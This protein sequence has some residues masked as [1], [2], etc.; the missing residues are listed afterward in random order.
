MVSKKARQVISVIVAWVYMITSYGVGFIATT[1]TTGCSNKKDDPVNVVVK[2]TAPDITQDGLPTQIPT[3]QDVNFKVIATPT[4]NAKPYTVSMSVSYASS[5]NNAN[6]GGRSINNGY[7]KIND[8]RKDLMDSTPVTYNYPEMTAKKDFDITL[9]A[10]RNGRLQFKID[11]ACGNEIV[12]IEKLIEIKSTTINVVIT[13]PV[14]NTLAHPFTASLS[15]AQTPLQADIKSLR[16][17]VTYPNLFPSDDANDPPQITETFNFDP[18]KKITDISTYY[19]SIPRA[20]DIS[21]FVELIDDQDNKHS[22]TRVFSIPNT[23]SPNFGYTAVIH[24]TATPY[25]EGT[26]YFTGTQFNFTITNPIDLDGYITELRYRIMKS[27]VVNPIVDWTPIE[28]SGFNVAFPDAGNYSILLRAIDNGGREKT[29]TVPFIIKSAVG[30]IATINIENENASYVAGNTI[31]INASGS[32]AQSGSSISQYEWFLV[33]PDNTE[34]LLGTG[35]RLTANQLNYV[36]VGKVKLIVTDTANR[37]TIAYKNVTVINRE[38]SLVMKKG[39]VNGSV[40]NT[41]AVVNT[42]VREK[43][44]LTAVASD[45]DVAIFK[46]DTPIDTLAYFWDIGLGNGYQSS[47]NDYLEFTPM[48]PNTTRTIKCKVVDL[49]GGIKEQTITVTVLDKPVINADFEIQTLSGNGPTNYRADD[50]FTFR[51]VSSPTDGATLTTQDWTIRFYDANDNEITEYM[52]D[53]ISGGILS[54]Y[55]LPHIGKVKVELYVKDSLMNESRKEQFIEIGSYTPSIEEGS[56]SISPESGSTPLTLTID[57][58]VIDQDL[59]L[60]DMG[61]NN[62]DALKID[63]YDGATK[64]NSTSFTSFPIQQ[65]VSGIGKKNIKIRITDNY[66]KYVESQSYEITVLAEKPASAVI[67]TKLYDNLT[68]TIITQ[69]NGILLRGTESNGRNDAPIINYKWTLTRVVNSA[70]TTTV[71]KEGDRASAGEF[72]YVPTF[73]GEGII[74]LEITDSNDAIASTSGAGNAVV[75]VINT[76]PAATGTTVSATQVSDNSAVTLTVN[77]AIDPDI[78]NFGDSLT[79]EFRTHESEQWITSANNNYTFTLTNTSYDH[80]NVYSL[81]ARVKDKYNGTWVSSPVEVRVLKRGSMAASLVV[82]NQP[83][84]IYR[85]DMLQIKSNVTLSTGATFISEYKISVKGPN[86]SFTTLIENNNYNQ[87]TIPNYAYTCDKIGQMTFQ[88]Y[89]KDSMGQTKT[90]EGDLFAVQN[91]RPVAAFTINGANTS[92]DT[93]QIPLPRNGYMPHLVQLDASNS[94]DPDG[95]SDTITYYWYVY[96]YGAQSSSVVPVTGKTYSLN[97]TLAML[98]TPYVIELRVVDAYTTLENADKIQQT[99]QATNTNPTIAKLTMTPEGSASINITTTSQGP[100]FIV[101]KKYTFKAEEIADAEITAGYQN[102]VY[103]W[104]INNVVNSEYTGNNFEFIPT[105][106]NTT[107]S[108]KVVVNDGF[109]STEKTY[110]RTTTN[111]V[112]EITI[113]KYDYNYGTSTYSNT[114][115]ALPSSGYELTAY[116]PI[117]LHIG[118]NDPDGHT[119]KGTGTALSIK[120]DGI[121]VSVL[122]LFETTTATSPISKVFT[123]DPLSPDYPFKHAKNG[124]A[125]CVYTIEVIATDNYGLQ[126]TVNIPITIKSALPEYEFFYIQDGNNY[127]TNNDGYVDAGINITTFENKLQPLTD[128]KELPIK[129]NTLF[130][131]KVKDTDNYINSTKITRQT[132]ETTLKLSGRDPVINRIS[133]SSRPLYYEDYL[134]MNIGTILVSDNNKQL[135]LTTTMNDKTNL[136]TDTM[137]YQTGSVNVKFK[138]TPPVLKK[139]TISGQKMKID[140]VEYDVGD[141]NSNI[142]VTLFEQ[143]D[144]GVIITNISTVLNKIELTLGYNYTMN[145]EAI[146]ADG[147]IISYKG[148]VVEPNNTSTTLLTWNTSNKSFVIPVATKHTHFA[149][150]YSKIEL[151]Y[152]DEYMGESG[153]AVKSYEFTTRNAAPI[154]SRIEYA[155][156]KINNNGST[157]V[158]GF[159]YDKDQTPQYPVPEIPRDVPLNLTFHAY[160][161]DGFIKEYSY[162]V[163]NSSNSPITGSS[164]TLSTSTTTIT[165]GDSYPIGEYAFVL[166]TK[167]GFDK[168]SGNINAGFKVVNAA[169]I[170]E[171]IKVTQNSKV[172]EIVLM[173][174]NVPDG[175]NIALVPDQPFAVEITGYDPDSITS[176]VSYTIDDIVSLIGATETMDSLKGIVGYS[177]PVIGSHHKLRATIKGNRDLATTKTINVAVA[178]TAPEMKVLYKIGSAPAN[179]ADMTEYNTNDTLTMI[180]GQSIYY[181]VKVKDI[182]RQTVSILRGANNTIGTVQLTQWSNPADEKIVGNTT[183]VVYSVGSNQTET[184]KATDSY[185][186]F[187]TVSV[188]YAV[189]NT[190]PTLTSMDVVYKG[191][192]TQKSG[193]DVVNNAVFSYMHTGSDLNTLKIKPNITDPDNGQTVDITNVTYGTGT[194]VASN[195]YYTINAQATQVGSKTLAITFSDGYSSVTQNYTINII[196]TPPNITIEPDSEIKIGSAQTGHILGV[197]YNL[198]YTVTENDNTKENDSYEWLK[199]IAYTGTPTDSPT[200]ILGKTITYLDSPKTNSVTINESVYY[201][202]TG[203]KKIKVTATNNMSG[204]NAT[205]FELLNAV[206]NAPPSFQGSIQYAFMGNNDFN[207]MTDSQLE[208]LGW[209]ATDYNFWLNGDRALGKVIF[210][211]VYTDNDISQGQNLIIT[212]GSSNTS[213]VTTGSIKQRSIKVNNTQTTYVTGLTPLTLGNSITLTARTKI[214]NGNWG[215]EQ[216]GEATQIINIQDPPP[217]FGENIVLLKKNGVNWDVVNEVVTGYDHIIL[218]SV[219]DLG[220]TSITVTQGL[221]ATALPTMQH[222]GVT[223]YYHE[224]T[225]NQNL[226]GM[227]TRSV[228]FKA[229]DS[230]NQE[231]LKEYSYTELNNSPVLVLFDTGNNNSKVKVSYI[232]ASGTEKTKVYASVY[233]INAADLI[234]D[235]TL[236]GRKFKISV[237]IADPDGHSIPDSVNDLKI[238]INGIGLSTRTF[239]GNVL[240]YEVSADVVRMLGTLANKNIEVYA[241]D[242]YTAALT[243]DGTQI[244]VTNTPAEFVS[245]NTVVDVEGKPIDPANEGVTLV[246]FVN[247]KEYTI[248]RIDNKYSVLPGVPVRVKTK[249]KDTAN[250]LTFNIKRFSAVGAESP[251]LTDQ[252]IA[253]SSSIISGVTNTYD[254]LA[255]SQFVPT[256]FTDGIGGKIRFVLTEK[257]NTDR[258]ISI[259][260]DIIK[261]VNQVPTVNVEL[262]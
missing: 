116:T 22:A 13:D 161:V 73:I 46:N 230:S 51:S 132:L 175:S 166:S 143:N 139:A 84:N 246:Y 39:G 251:M 82:L 177:M 102:A 204:N 225:P 138:N 160:D 189:S 5:Q 50:K 236:T 105:S 4:T 27:G 71:I 44:T 36:G 173:N 96:Q 261:A 194:L 186:A 231:V 255:P 253:F 156:T 79:Y 256:D 237:K 199:E 66:G 2:V 68:S 259:E 250:N 254:G 191:I 223:Y 77:G 188:K 187:T 192:A 81:Y 159:L 97:P 228:T 214:I 142:T 163:N 170:I 14:V 217:V 47:P 26:E 168:P 117:K 7:I 179:D 157:Q 169:P 120:R 155:Y 185:G 31:D 221:S 215:V 98:T 104:Y 18:A 193:N 144:G 126:K 235:G 212:L 200:N 53:G 133:S 49:Y 257:L 209:S 148:V 240:S 112:P 202:N 262:E 130:V 15:V 74:S 195:G 9:N 172:Q 122:N 183:A 203:N 123:F 134:V 25:V 11:A 127:D 226:D 87:N 247:E 70:T 65:E 80:D 28:N 111:N 150:S 201:T 94:V 42:Y 178:N 93:L 54:N 107:Y 153:A 60:K 245:L 106:V 135:I 24:N 85:G 121:P 6:D 95:I 115:T 62:L 227:A 48:E 174:N 164:A 29:T 141:N 234:T 137:Y 52:Q 243:Y 64:L 196:T 149:N 162:V 249:V 129:N 140:G 35:V 92:N 244:K 131:V 216:S 33:Y 258:V 198:K 41:G 100:G 56:F 146:D 17:V 114:L 61:D 181:K 30:P 136:N 232:D 109:A 10:L 211:Y 32:S 260:K 76:N 206:T 208:A 67:S 145:F 90:V 219:T 207:T 252:S 242:Q 154:I 23:Y 147:H 238:V 88:L 165:L 91:R 12:K 99:I 176:V 72:R 101:D 218:V 38:P 224:F 220:S 205:S 8:E 20:G 184:F 19:L 110:T 16:Y 233:D 21:L 3:N 167:D 118:V 213:V 59:T 34:R 119:L 241:K 45:P 158:S 1:T 171:K 113:Q 182:D 222:N 69:N 55:T 239:S 37:S 190:A 248:P 197:T 108:I 128:N 125:E 78:A 152:G 86:E 180:A 229:K 83:T 89:V 151:R 103:T 57:A 43:L 75:R 124:G 58:S 40:I 63:V 210:R